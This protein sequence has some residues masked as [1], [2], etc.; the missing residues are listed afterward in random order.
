VQGECVEEEMIVTK[1]RMEFLGADWMKR[2]ADPE[3][4]SLAELLYHVLM[5]EVVKG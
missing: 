1:L 5:A 4:M 3:R 2:E